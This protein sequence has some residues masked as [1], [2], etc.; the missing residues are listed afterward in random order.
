MKGNR[1]MT[2]RA[3]PAIV[4][5]LRAA[6]LCAA[7]L[8]AAGAAAELSGAYRGIGEAEGMRLEI[9]PAGG[10]FRGALV[11]TDG[12]RLPF[13][14]A[15]P[16]TAAEGRIEDGDLTLFLRVAEKPMGLEAVIV[17][18]DA[19]GG[20]FVGET[21][22]LAFLRPGLDLPEPPARP[23]PPPERRGQRVEARGFVSSFPFWPP[24]AVAWGYEGL[25]PRFRTAI[26]LFPLVQADLAWK[27][28]QSPDR[29]PGVADALR[30]QGLDCADVLAVF[31]RLRR[32]EGWDRFKKAVAG[33]RAVLM[34]VLDCADDLTRTQRDCASAA[35]ETAERALS[36][37]TVATALA[38]FR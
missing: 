27:L 33:E 9:E 3:M 24:L 7:T 32:G 8:W 34:Q 1:R 6:T 30:G 10:G 35:G 5:T 25:E 4:A 20:V 23:L 18:V 37:E 22:T 19:E 12:K 11:G 26:R 28:C 15:G 16:A 2:K 21:R 38:R 17:P 36:M 13:S 31:D 14:L 29:T